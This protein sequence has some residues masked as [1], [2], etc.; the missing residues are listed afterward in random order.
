MEA[1]AARRGISG[2]TLVEQMLRDAAQ[3]EGLRVKGLG[4]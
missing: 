2:T 3:A 1:L 4:K